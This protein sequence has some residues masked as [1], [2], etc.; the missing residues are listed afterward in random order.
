MQMLC[1]K[2]QENCQCYKNYAIPEETP[3]CK[4]VNK[5]PPNFTDQSILTLVI[6]PGNLVMRYYAKSALF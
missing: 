6:K 2:P 1:L 5:K 4:P 3:I